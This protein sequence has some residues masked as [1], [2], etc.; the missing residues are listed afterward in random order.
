MPRKAGITDVETVDKEGNVRTLEHPHMDGLEVMSFA[1]RAVPKTLKDV[2][3]ILNW[4]KDD[5]DIFALHQANELMLNTLAKRIKVPAEKVPFSLKEY[6]NTA[7]ASVPITLCS[8]SSRGREFDRTFMC[9]FGNG[10]ACAAAA[11]SLKDTHFCSP[12]KF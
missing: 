10:L 1:I 12:Y 3:N 6:G 7:C 8:E 5:I 2:L 11:L 9:G 4:N